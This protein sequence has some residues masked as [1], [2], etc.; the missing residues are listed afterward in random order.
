M[1]PGLLSPGE[2]ERERVG[3]GPLRRRPVAGVGFFG[4]GVRRLRGDRRGPFQRP[5]R[6][7]QAEV[8]AEVSDLVVDGGVQEPLGGRVVVEAVDDLVHQALDLTPASVGLP[9]TAAEAE[10]LNDPKAVLHQAVGQVRGRR[11]PV[12]LGQIFP[13]IAQ[14]QNLIELRKTASFATFEASVKAVLADLGCL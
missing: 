4:H 11:R 10:R 2:A 8:A 13:A 3:R 12:D 7:Q 1:S 14:R 9:S 6:Q 5:L